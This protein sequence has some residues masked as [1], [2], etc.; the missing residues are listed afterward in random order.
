M[1]RDSG[2]AMSRDTEALGPS[3]CRENEWLVARPTDLD[4]SLPPSLGTGSAFPSAGIGSDSRAGDVIDRQLTQL[5]EF[6][7]FPSWM[8]K[9]SDGCDM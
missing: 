2:E 6:G 1:F 7:G 5:L 3:D 9:G 4:T 8:A